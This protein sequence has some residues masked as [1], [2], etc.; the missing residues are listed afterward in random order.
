VVEAIASGRKAATSIDRYLG[1]RW[2]SDKSQ[3][4]RNNQ[5]PLRF[6]S[7]FLRKTGRVRLPELSV[8]K[9]IK[10]IENED[11]GDVELKSITRESQRC[12]NCGCVAVN[13]SDL[14]PALI[15]LDAKIQTSRRTIEAQEFFAVAGDRSTVLEDDEI[16]TEIVVPAPLPDT[17]FDFTK[18][19]MRKSIDFPVVNCAAAV[20]HEKGKVKSARIC[21][22][23]VYNQPYRVKEAEEYIH[24]KKITGPIASEAAE[25][26]VKEA[27]PLI[28]NQYKVQVAKTLVKRA[29]L[30]CAERK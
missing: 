29:I 18:F 20:Q 27:F 26:G 24:G 16:V 1:D 21:L 9:R 7:S 11:T 15:A 22:N 28:N 10:S 4:D 3:C 8:E 23:A 6:E 13:P 12:F 25:R 14:A 19:A 17:R 2:P 30:A 5:T